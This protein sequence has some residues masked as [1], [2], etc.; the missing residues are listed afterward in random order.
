MSAKQGA[1]RFLGFLFFR[2]AMTQR[3]LTSLGL[4][5]L[6]VL[7]YLLAGGKC[8]RVPDVRPGT[9]FGSVAVGS[10]TTQPGQSAD[11]RDKPASAKEQARTSGARVAQQGSQQKSQ[12]PAVVAPD[13][14]VDPLAEIERRL[15]E[16]DGQP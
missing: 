12:A 2:S 4:V 6:F 15:M 9:S 7:F 3:N 5:G 8:V 10:Q 14:D 1:K 11:L 16:K 13:A